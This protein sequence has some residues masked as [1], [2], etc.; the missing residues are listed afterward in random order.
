MGRRTGRWQRV[1]F[2]PSLRALSRGQARRLRGDLGF[3]VRSRIILMRRVYLQ[4]RGGGYVAEDDVKP[5]RTTSLVGLSLRLPRQ[6]VTD[7]MSTNGR[8]FT[9]AR[10]MS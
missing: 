3:E 2:F 4:T 7:L 5:L 1:R 9:Q 10:I 8:E 6:Y